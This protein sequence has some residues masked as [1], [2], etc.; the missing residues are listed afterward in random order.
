MRPRIVIAAAVSKPI[1]SGSRIRLSAG[2]TRSVLYAPSGLPVYVT[3]S[4]TASPATLP[5]TAVTMPAAST[6]MPDGSFAG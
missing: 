6:P 4:P 2:I 3:R 5:P 1:A